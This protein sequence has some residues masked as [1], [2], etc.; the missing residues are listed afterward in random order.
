M[1]SAR[2]SCYALKASITTRLGPLDFDLPGP[3]FTIHHHYPQTVSIIYLWEMERKNN[4]FRKSRLNILNIM[5]F[6][7]TN[8]TNAISFQRQLKI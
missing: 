6:S 5:Y 2:V 1:I 7:K 3:K 4:I 8:F